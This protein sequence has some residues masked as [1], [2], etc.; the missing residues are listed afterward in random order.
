VRLGEEFHHNGLR[1]QCAQ[2]SQ[3]PRGLA[4]TW[5]RYRLAAETVRLLQTYGALIKAHLITDVVP[6]NE[7]PQLIA[8]LAARRRHVLQ[9][10]F[11][12][13]PCV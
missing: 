13:T 7:A 9:A 12:V 4:H 8:E 3:V 5:N 2:I 10:I 11:A 1:I 6:F